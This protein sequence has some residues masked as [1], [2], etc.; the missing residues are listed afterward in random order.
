LLH[1]ETTAVRSLAMSALGGIADPTAIAPL[2]ALLGD[3]DE[4][5]RID[6]V[7]ALGRTGED[8]TPAEAESCLEHLSGCLNDPSD[9]VRRQTHLW[10]EAIRKKAGTA[11]K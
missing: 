11:G 1:S 9:D 3:R 10:I 8:A 6:A 4:K 7:E 2:S 5:I